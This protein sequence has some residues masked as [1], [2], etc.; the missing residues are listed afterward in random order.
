MKVI[1]LLGF[2]VSNILVFGQG[3]V[4]G[5][6]K[7]IDDETGKEKSIVHIYHKQDGKL[8][9]KIVKLLNRVKGDEN[10]LCT[11]CPNELKNKPI[12]GMEIIKGLQK[13]DEVYDEGTILSPKKGKIY[14]CKIWLDEKNINQLNVRGYIA[15]FFRTQHWIRVLE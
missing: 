5:K 3:G 12:L 6:W 7:T 1:Y 13:N 15:F 2:L 14:D 11:K 8:Y 4:L 10:P 9:G